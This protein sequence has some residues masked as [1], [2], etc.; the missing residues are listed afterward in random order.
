MHPIHQSISDIE[1]ELSS[2]NIINQ[3][4][5]EFSLDV[6]RYFRDI[7]KVEIRKCGKTG[8]RYYYPESLIGDNYFY[9]SFLTK[10]DYSRDWEFD[11]K[12]AFQR[13]NPES[14]LLEIGCGSGKFL[15]KIRSKNVQA[16]GLELNEDMVSLCQNDGLN[17]TNES[18][19]DF[20]Y[21]NKNKFNTV[22]VFQVI[23]HVYY[24]QDFIEDMLY[25]LKENGKLII[26]TP[27][28]NPY[29][30]KYHKNETLNLP[31]HHM[32]LWNLETFNGVANHLQLKV[33]SHDYSDATT[34]N[35]DVFYCS[36]QRRKENKLFSDFKWLN[37]LISCAVVMKDRATNKPQ[38][39]FIVVE[40]CKK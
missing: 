16:V 30:A 9:Q 39:N 36:M 2:K 19:S 40:I 26:S 13:V 37:F 6:R 8:L 17:V 5:N 10:G 29:Y 27:N 25:C 35:G 33:N 22:C 7:D 1:E 38:G 18:L 24:V 23:E 28:S 14:T 3:Y 34:L 32:T 15:K 12:F 21:K 4:K 31:P 11:H 20:K